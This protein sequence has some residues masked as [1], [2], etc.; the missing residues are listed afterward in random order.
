MSI[1]TQ[2]FLA[3]VGSD[4]MSFTFS[5]AGHLVS[6]LSVSPCLIMTAGPINVKGTGRKQTS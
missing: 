6:L 1:L 3:L 4:L 2:L 5:S